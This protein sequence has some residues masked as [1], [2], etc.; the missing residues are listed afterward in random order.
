[1]CTIRALSVLV[2]LGMGRKVKV[3]IWKMALK[4]VAW[5]RALLAQCAKMRDIRKEVSVTDHEEP[6]SP[7]FLFFLY[8]YERSLCSM[9]SAL[10]CH[11][12]TQLTDIPCEVGRFDFLWLVAHCV[13]ISSLFPLS[14]LPFHGE[15]E[16]V[17]PQI[18]AYQLQHNG[19]RG[20]MIFSL[21]TLFYM[22]LTE[23][24]PPTH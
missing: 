13:H 5:A 17:H 7:L 10:S 21:R 19:H 4:P 12:W 16:D 15:R 9:V 6:Q 20:G 3:G 14:L 24:L 8:L 23:L 22:C 18:R 1:M 11:R 2:R